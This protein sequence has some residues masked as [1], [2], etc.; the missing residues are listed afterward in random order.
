MKK[1]LQTIREKLQQGR[2]LDLAERRRAIQLIDE[3][4]PPD[5]PAVE[6]HREDR[7]KKKGKGK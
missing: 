7:P 5:E 1:D 4:D 6:T 3:V 2:E